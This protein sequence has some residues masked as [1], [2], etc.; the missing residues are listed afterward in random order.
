MYVVATAGHVDHGKSTLVRL[1]TGM[2]PDRWAEERR[3]GMTIDLGFAWTTLPTGETV[4]FVDVP[5]HERFVGNMLAGVGPVPAVMFVV[6]ADEGWKAQS[7]E[8]LDAVHALGVE[9]GLLVVTRCDLAD[10]AAAETEAL[11]QLAATTLA[12]I[13]AV[14]V[15][16]R[17][18]D[19][20]DLLRTVLHDMVSALPPSTV[21][22]PVRLWVDRAFTIRGAGTVVTGTLAGG[23]IRSGD[24]FVHGRTGQRIAVR[25]LQSL[26]SA[27][28]EVRG[29]ARV[30]LNLRGVALDEIGRGDTLLTPGRWLR[31]DRVD[32]R[33]RGDDAADL[34]TELALH[35]GS[36]AVQARVRPLGTDTARLVLDRPLPLRIGD[37]CVL[38]DPGRRRIA[39]GAVVLDVRPAP[40]RRRG[41]AG[42]RAGV[43]ATMDGTPDGAAEVRRRGIVRTS[44][45]LAMGATAPAPDVAPGWLVDPKLAERLGSRIA[46][47][48]RRYA[49]EHPLEA[50]VPVDVVRREL[51]L[52]DPR[53]VTAL[54]RA[55]LAARE[56]RI[57]AESR[58]LPGPVQAAVDAV[59]RELAADPYAA[60]DANRLSELGLTG[61]ELAAA[62]RTGALL[63]V[64]DGVFLLPGADAEAAA[65]LARLAQPFTLSQARQEL[66]T[67]R[68]VAVPLLELLARQGRTRRTADGGHEVVPPAR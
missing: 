68:R 36:A 17:T 44:D 41:A 18:G 9:H 57:T 46:E 21:D 20:I 47:T 43:L 29:T 55:P 39:A 34:P 22:G 64:A 25:A 56:G 8:H 52:P 59:R 4:A 27:A 61:R 13:P 23:R 50:G 60:P 58:Q 5:G 33:L 3:R 35:L 26:G 48:A 62:A 42:T 11:A 14:R 54:V 28:D 63:K 19:G 7:G 2:E 65:R 53:L 32:V 12:T 31:T 15:S 45:L 10:P 66:G 30:A 40:L 1:L 51:G 24:E 49:E 67:T 16:G 37:V 38:R 6:A